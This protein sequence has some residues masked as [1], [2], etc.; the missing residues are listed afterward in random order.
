MHDIRRIS[1][2]HGL[3]YPMGVQ[4]DQVN[5]QFVGHPTF[6]HVNK[7]GVGYPTVDEVNVFSR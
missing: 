5:D 2:E 7:F 4:F 1:D 3:G 6:D